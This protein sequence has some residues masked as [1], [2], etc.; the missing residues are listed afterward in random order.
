MSTTT[1]DRRREHRHEVQQSLDAFV[2]FDHPNGER[3]RVPLLDLSVAGL[4]FWL[5]A[6]LAE[7]EPGARF[8]D[9]EVHVGDGSIRGELLVLRV[10]PDSEADAGVSCGAYF[11]PDTAA[12]LDK[13]TCLISGLKAAQPGE[14]S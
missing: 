8:S 12:E 10:D 3:Q 7:V 4:A 11:Y 2:E 5:P 14:S 9:V 6:W 13:M 1:K